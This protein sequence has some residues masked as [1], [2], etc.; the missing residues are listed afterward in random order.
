[1]VEMIRLLQDTELKP[2]INFWTI[3][4]FATGFTVGF[5][6]M[7]PK[8][9]IIIVIL[10]EVV[11][12]GLLVPFGIVGPAEL[13]LDSIIDIIFGLIGYGI[14]LFIHSKVKD[15]DWYK[16]YFDIL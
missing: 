15:T 11:E 12:Q 2:P 4:H 16:R 14:G 13:L 8:Y 9:A 6:G 5:L 7:S 3:A 10:W 1:M